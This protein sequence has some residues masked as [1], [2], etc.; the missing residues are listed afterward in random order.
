MQFFKNKHL[1]LAMFVAPVLALL[2]YFAVD[3][4]V[5]EQP[6]AAQP[7]AS[8]RLAALS[9]CRYQSGKCTLKNGELEMSFRARR[10]ADSQVE[11]ILQSQYPLGNTLV[12]IVHGDADSAPVPMQRHNPQ[13]DGLS[14]TLNI[15][16]P[17][18]SLLRLA[19]E[20][21]G[22]LYYAETSAI[23]V[24]YETSFTRENFSDE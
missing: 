11:L 9:N 19:V 2:A 5:T 15:D 3:Y 18:K 21:S 12:S 16:E 20:V 8:Y 13:A 10:L 7:G 22:A 23:F 6:H 17:D 1:I 14:V 24:D 4:A